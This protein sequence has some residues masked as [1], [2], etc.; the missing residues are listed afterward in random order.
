MAHH[1][2]HGEISKKN[3]VIAMILNFVITIGEIIGGILSGSLSLI[4]DALHNFSDGISIIV[5]YIAIK[6]SKKENNEKMTFGY[7]RAEILAALFNSVVLVVIS[8]YL[9]KEAYIKFFKPEPIDGALMI[10]V[11]TIGLAAN[12]KPPD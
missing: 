9:F 12:K 5:S 3:L 8:L 11:A 1:H 6:I 10:V 2:D 4:S 7:K